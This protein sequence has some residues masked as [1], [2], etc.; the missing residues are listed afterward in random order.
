MTWNQSGTMQTIYGEGGGIDLYSYTWDPQTGGILL[1]ES[2][3]SFSKEPRPVYPAEMNL[4]EFDR[5]WNYDKDGSVP[6]MWAESGNYYYRGN[7]IAKVKGGSAF[8]SPELIVV[9]DPNLSKKNLDPIDIE[10]MVQKNRNL[11]EP[12][13]QETIRRIYSTYIQYLEKVDVFYVAFSGGKDSLV[14]LD[15]VQRTIPHQD[16]KVLFG[17]T[18]MEFPDTYSVVSDIK[19]ECYKMGIEFLESKSFLHPSETW[20]KFGPP[21]TVVRWCCSVHKTA[22]QIIKLREVTGKP[23]FTGMAFIGV[24]ASESLSRSDYDYISLGEKHKGQYSCNPILEWNSA[25]LFLYMYSFNVPISDA[26]KKGNRR[27]GCLL[28]PRASEKN[29]FICHSCYPTEFESLLDSIKKSYEGMFD[30]DDKLDEFIQNGGWKARKNGRD[31]A[32]D[33]NYHEYSSEN[34]FR[35]EI[36]HP[37]ADWKMWIKTIG[38][39]TVDESPYIIDYDGSLCEFSV[40]N[41]RDLLVVS[42]DLD[43][44]KT[45]ASFVKSLKSV[46]HK[47]SCC[48][49]CGVCAANCHNGFI[50]MDGIKTTI[51]DSCLHCRQCHK[52]DKGCILYK[53]LEKPT[54]SSTMAR[55]KSLNC[56]SHHAPKLAWFEQFFEY[57]NE[58]DQKYNMGSQMY[59]F[60]KRFLRDA[61]LLDKDGF[62]EFAQL[63]DRLGLDNRSSWGLMLVNL[64]YT[65]QINWVVTKMR[66]HDVY[67]R[68]FVENLLINDGADEKWVKDVWSSIVRTSE[69]P[70][71]CVGYC[72]PM[73]NQS[74]SK[75]KIEAVSRIPWVNPDPLV[76]LYSLFRFKEACDGYNQFPVSRL[77]DQ[78]VES[79]GVTPYQQFGIEKDQ[80]EKLL[81]GLAQ[82][83]P[84]MISTKFTLD[85]DAIELNPEKTSKDVLQLF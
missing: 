65:P 42:F 22:P 18:E 16:F 23:N 69:L 47:V 7:L 5:Y 39:L 20:E 19:N 12:L 1:N 57:K 32:I 58:F 35:I 37:R 62:T 49:N 66:F 54:G 26:Y 11:L 46:F 59:S 77:F 24:R 9:E 68:Q 2:P 31:L 48:I 38:Q 84:D 40:E 4:L 56:Y 14:T 30:S 41:S 82:N 80:I 60:F 28:C 8:T 15:L 17:N 29:E 50:Q 55:T 27:V 74:E 36:N 52:V 33:L 75:K 71:N 76:I 83:Y 67:E 44:L 13:V 34:K 10:A 6:I 64:S 78:E 25:E 53:S 81:N 3:L 73:K 72:S 45:N 63:V 70:F 79:E 85:L 51:S 61:E 43:Y 21:A